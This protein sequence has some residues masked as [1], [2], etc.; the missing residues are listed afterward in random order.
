[1]REPT[2]TCVGGMHLLETGASCRKLESVW[3]EIT[4]GG[5]GGSCSLF[6][7]E[8]PFQSGFSACGTQRGVPDIA[9]VADPYTGVLVYLGS[10][11]GGPGLFV[12]GGTSLA[13]P[14]MAAIVA[15]V[16]ASRVAQGKTILGGSATSFNLTSLLYQAAVSPFYHYRLYDVTAGTNAEAGWDTATG[17]GVTLNPALA[18]YLDSLP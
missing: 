16:D 10:N 4:G 1:M 15:I 11:A 17:L 18:A 2:V 12:I 7:S 14:V 3:D 8:P 5:T 9:A 6:E 13:S